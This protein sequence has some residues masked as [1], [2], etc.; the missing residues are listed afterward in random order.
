MFVRSWMS[1]PAVVL[2]GATPVSDALEYMAIRKIRRIPVMQDG[3]LA[4]IVT[5]S[6][7]QAVAARHDASGRTSKIV[8]ADVMKA[9][10]LTIASD[11][12]LENASKI[13]LKNELS[14]LPVMD[15]DR[16]LGM[17]TE[18]DIFEA[19]NEIMGTAES[20]ARIVMTV[21]ADTQL[22]DSLRRR[23]KGLSIR[24]LATYRDEDGGDWQVV[25]K[26]CGR[27]PAGVA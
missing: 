4:G 25:V 23:L 11:D 5:R 9:P 12:T 22:L 17:I 24:S 21:L 10:V 2:Q 27:K 1:S 19:F 6:D 8:L 13:M 16:L 18:S 15:G 26:V 20:G 7:L 14:G 3:V